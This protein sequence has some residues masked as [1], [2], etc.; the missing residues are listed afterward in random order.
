[1][2]VGVQ[3]SVAVDTGLFVAF[4]PLMNSHFH[5]TIT[6]ELMTFRMLLQQ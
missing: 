4:K 2:L 3:N 6:V 5:F 1:M